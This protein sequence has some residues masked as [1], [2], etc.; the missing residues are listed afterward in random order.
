MTASDMFTAIS[1]G[2]AAHV[3][4]ISPQRLRYWEKTGL[5]TPDVERE[6]SPRN[7]VRL[8]SLPRVVE[9]VAA[10]ESSSAPPRP[11]ATTL[12]QVMAVAAE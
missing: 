5:V 9:L 10:S 11:A 12:Q 3:A 1:D 6:I 4:A 7:V 8:Y 2:R